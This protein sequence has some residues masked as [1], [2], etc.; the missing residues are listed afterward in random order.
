MPFLRYAAALL[1]AAVLSAP[2]A[3]SAQERGDPIPLSQYQRVVQ[4]LGWAEIEVEYRRPVARGRDLFGA[5]VPF[6]E[7]WTPSADS[8]VVFSTTHDL[9]VAGERLPA[10]DYS[11]WIVPRASAPWTV[12]FSHAARVFHQP[13]PEGQDALRLLIP[14]WNGDHMETLSLYFPVVNRGEATFAL[15]WGSRVLPLPI[16][17]PDS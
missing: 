16:A 9:E 5:L 6:D 7:A 10:G 2:G 17:L 3:A 4:R 1:F 12:I 15:H 13:Y 14:A 11:L 8:A